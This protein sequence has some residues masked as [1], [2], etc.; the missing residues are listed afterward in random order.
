MILVLV[1]LAFI[2]PIISPHL[3]A[4]GLPETYGG[5]CLGVEGGT[6]FLGAI[7]VGNITSY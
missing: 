1:S 5:Y 6:H 4:L 7:I 2:D 3:F